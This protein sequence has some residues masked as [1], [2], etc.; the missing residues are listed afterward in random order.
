MKLEETDNEI[1]VTL[2]LL[3]HVLNS[4]VF[5]FQVVLLVFPSIT[6]DSIF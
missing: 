3:F 6:H 2:I 5:T 4:D 1:T